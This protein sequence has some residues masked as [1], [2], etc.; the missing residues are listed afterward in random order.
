MFEFEQI[1]AEH[2]DADSVC[3][4]SNQ[5]LICYTNCPLQLQVKNCSVP[6]QLSIRKCKTVLR[7]FS[8]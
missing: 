2:V 6:V 3:I 7:F 4:V 1:S 8:W 5:F